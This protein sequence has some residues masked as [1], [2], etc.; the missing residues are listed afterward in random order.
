MLFRREGDSVFVELC[1]PDPMENY[2]P[3]VDKM[4]AS[5]AEQF[6]PNLLGVVLTGMGNDGSKGVRAIKDA[7]GQ[8]LSEA[9]ETAVI[10]GM[11]REALATGAVDAVVPLERMA[12]EILA[13]SGSSGLE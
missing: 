8:V 6:G 12:A 1:N 13:R 7:G 9:E 11:P 10:F 3:S 5:S 2:L 4:F